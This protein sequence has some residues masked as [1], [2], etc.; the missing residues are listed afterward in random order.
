MLDAG[1][2]MQL[3]A[4]RGGRQAGPTVSLGSCGGLGRR[5]D[6]RK[7]SGKRSRFVR[8]VLEVAEKWPVHG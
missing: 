8:V 1:A 6:E 3:R 7:R 2:Q 5:F 4:G